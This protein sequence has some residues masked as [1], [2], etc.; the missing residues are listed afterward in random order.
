MFVCQCSDILVVCDQTHRPFYYLVVVL[1]LCETS[2][3]SCGN[4]GVVPAGT[5]DCLTSVL[6]PES[7]ESIV[8]SYD[9]RL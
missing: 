5:R 1:W 3:S 2:G 8:P 4:G 7:Q 9:S 6:M